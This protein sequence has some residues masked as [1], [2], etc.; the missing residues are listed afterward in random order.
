[1][2]ILRIK[3]AVLHVRFL[4]NFVSQDYC[5]N[6]LIIRRNFV[7]LMCRNLLKIRNLSIARVSECD[8]HGPDYNEIS[9]CITKTYLFA[10]HTA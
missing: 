9:L 4:D 10:T 7:V 8:F 5:V 3:I 2:V 1:M 6:C